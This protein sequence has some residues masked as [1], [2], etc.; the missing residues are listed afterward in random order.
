MSRKKN[1]YLFILIFIVIIFVILGYLIYLFFDETNIFLPE[2]IINYFI[3][4]NI[5]KIV[6]LRYYKEDESIV[7]E[8]KYPQY[9]DEDRFLCIWKC[10]NYK[11]EK[12]PHRNEYLIIFNRN[13]DI[14]ILDSEVYTGFY[15]IS[16]NKKYIIYSKFYSSYESELCIYYLEKKQS[17]DILKIDIGKV[18]WDLNDEYII[19]MKDDNIFKFKIEN[20]TLTK[21]YSADESIRIN[22]VNEN[23]DIVITLKESNMMMI[24]DL[25]G[26]EKEIINPYGGKPSRWE[27]ILTNF[28]FSPNF[29]FIAFPLK[30]LPYLKIYDLRKRKTY[31]IYQFDF[32]YFDKVTWS[33]DSKKLYFIQEDETGNYC[34]Y[35]LKIPERILK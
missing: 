2:K 21:I 14:D 19:F 28:T 7:E 35:E 9:F 33:S 23:N 12:Y 22:D 10:K 17:R 1:I 26:N 25:S 5:K 4:P 30:G 18:I 6:E 15:S 27:S 11:P 16:H 34:L 8:F 13:G 31:I 29:R 3:N 24:I 20:N 32:F